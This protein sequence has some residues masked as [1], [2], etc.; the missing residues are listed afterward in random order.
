MIAA[1]VALPLIGIVGAI[2]LW[3]A[4]DA[5]NRAEE[6]KFTYDESAVVNVDPSLVKYQQVER[7]DTGLKS[8]RAIALDRAGRLYVAG[9]RKLLV[10]TSVTTRPTTAPAFSEL[11]L[12]DTPNAVCIAPDGSIYL[13]MREH[14]EVY[15]AMGRQKASWPTLGEQSYLTSIAVTEDRVWLADYGRKVLVACTPAGRVVFEAGR[16]DKAM[17]YDGLAVPSPH[18][19]VA[20]DANGDA[21]VANPGRCRLEKF[22]RGG[23]F[24]RM[25]GKPGGTVDGF[26]GC[27]NPC[28]FALLSDGRFVTAEKGVPRVRIFSSTGQFEC[29]VAPPRAFAQEFEGFDMAVDAQDRILILQRPGNVVR[30]FAPV[31]GGTR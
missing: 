27:C 8:A 26:Y 15:D 17:N 10:L 1:L 13:A 30:V 20:V 18:M 25:W 19:D 3:K 23:H 21:W 12:P 9:D 22:D 28:E 6:S 16:A 29:F 4:S 7:I 11:S 24:V 14:V 31:D 5:K 2:V